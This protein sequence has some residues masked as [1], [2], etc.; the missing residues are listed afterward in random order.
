MSS[1]QLFFNLY[2]PLAALFLLEAPFAMTCPCLGLVPP[3]AVTLL[4][5]G[6]ILYMTRST[7]ALQ[8]SLTS[9]FDEVMSLKRVRNKYHISGYLLCATE[10]NPFG[11]RLPDGKL[12]ILENPFTIVIK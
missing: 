8:N 3:V 11:A 10:G 2:P 1:D 5:F 9:S 12:L 6:C 7:M 4:D